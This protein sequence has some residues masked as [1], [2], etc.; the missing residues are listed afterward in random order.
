MVFK[1]FSPCFRIRAKTPTWGLFTKA[2]Y[3]NTKGS[4]TLDTKDQVHEWGKSSRALQDSPRCAL[5]VFHQTRQ[6][7]FWRGVRAWAVRWS[8][9]HSL[10]C[11]VS[12]S[13]LCR[14]DVKPASSAR[15]VNGSR[16]TPSRSGFSEVSPCDPPSGE[17]V[18]TYPLA[19]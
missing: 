12:L 3:T 8:L 4:S 5:N 7:M 10:H 19:I 14:D 17:C 1:S 13:L 15:S 11:S 18:F 9:S 2:H 16:P 6:W